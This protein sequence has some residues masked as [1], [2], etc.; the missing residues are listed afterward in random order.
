MRIYFLSYTPAILKL[1]G[2]YAGGIDLFERHLDVDLND[3]I[4][5]EIVPGENLQ[6]VNF[7]LNKK[8][9]EAP[10]EFMDVY[11]LEGDALLYVRSYGCKD[12]RLKVVWQSRFC[13]N[14]ITVFLQGGVYLSLEGESY[15]L[16][17]LHL[18]FKD[19]CAEEL[20]LCGFPV[21]AIRGGNYL[22]IISHTGKRIFYNEV[23]SA[24]FGESL[25][26]CVQFETCTAARAECEYSYDGQKLTLVKSRTVESST[27]DERIMHFAFFESV[28][29]CGDYQ[30]YLSP[31]L[32][33]RAGDV[34]SYLGEFVGVSV[35]TEKF[36]CEHPKSRA[37]G[38][39][40]P[41]SA[42]LYEVKYFA[43]DI[44]DGKIDN[45]YP[46]E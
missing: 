24:E 23:L 46:V 44:A 29:T 32:L 30:K 1:N 45:V 8:M 42:N 18:R 4:M 37:A 9:L 26:I 41:K 25:K 27:P 33:P 13:G 5:A 7:F 10:P 22:L 12:G 15:E 2:L 36:F 43:V 35:P 16:L 31:A 20:T 28:L 38:L 6:P 40:Y 3:N 21:L 19:A 14:L 39:I 34:K 17:P 11:L